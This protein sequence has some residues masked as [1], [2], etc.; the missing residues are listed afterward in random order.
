MEKASFEGSSPL[1]NWA[2]AGKDESILVDSLYP[3]SLHHLSPV[4]HRDDAYPHNIAHNT[5]GSVPS[6]ALDTF[7]SWMTR[8]WNIFRLR[9]TEQSTEWKMR[10]IRNT[11]FIC[12]FLFDLFYLLA[13]CLLST[14][15]QSLL[16]SQW[17]FEYPFTIIFCSYWCCFPNPPHFLQ[18]F[19]NW[20][21]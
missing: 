9:D 4:R 7:P 3:T 18:D 15:I 16:Y 21:A 20:I 6:I 13:N 14:W 17:R 1:R 12:F 19:V 8:L 11:Q 5:S 10:I 2:I